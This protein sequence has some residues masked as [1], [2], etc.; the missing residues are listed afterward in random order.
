[1]LPFHKASY[2][3]GQS[4]GMKL[5][6]LIRDTIPGTILLYR[7]IGRALSANISTKNICNRKSIKMMLTHRE[8]AAAR[9]R[10]FVRD[11]CA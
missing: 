5:A 6:P 10:T 1:M 9:V 11:D 4:G 7:E 2:R 3:T 8:I